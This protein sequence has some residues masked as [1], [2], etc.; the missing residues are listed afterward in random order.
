VGT[1]SGILAL[2]TLKLGVSMVRAVDID[3]IAIRVAQEN[4]ERNSYTPHP[5]PL[6]SRGEGVQVETAVGSAA[7]SGS[8]KWEVVVANILANTLVELMP[9]LAAALAPGGQLILSG[10]LAEQ[11]ASV[12][13]AATIQHLCL[14][15]RRTESDWVALVMEQER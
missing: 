5:N 13:E 1:G 12:V 7:D 15:D 8:R 10:L 11:E 2:A 3:D 9:D 14:S 4:F 6:P